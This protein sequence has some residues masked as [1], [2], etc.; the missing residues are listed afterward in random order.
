[1]WRSWSAM[2][3][4]I[5]TGLFGRFTSTVPRHH[6]LAV[7]GSHH[8]PEVMH[9]PDFVPVS[10]QAMRSKFDAIGR[11][12]EL[13]MGKPFF[14][15]DA[16]LDTA[17]RQIGV[18]AGA[19]DLV[20]QA[21]WELADRRTYVKWA[22]RT[23]DVMVIGMP[24]S[25]HYGDGMG[26]NP[27]LM[28]Q[29]IS[30]QIIRQQ[31]V[32]SDHPVV[33]CSSVCDGYFHDEEFPAYREVYGLFQRDRAATLPDVEKFGEALSRD[34]RYIDAYRYRYGYHPFHLHDDQL[35]THRR[36]EVRGHLHEWGEGAGL[37]RVMGMNTRAT[38][39]EALADARAYRPD[40]A[41]LALPALKTAR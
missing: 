16:V 10:T 23:Y 11:H 30:A 34:Q 40:A 5:H 17:S 4:A 13:R 8:S 41:I 1:M 33:I 15:V 22:K 14:T 37:C 39:E 20:Q 38:F 6:P 26:T 35:R 25:F 7:V 12:M 36:T 21:C 3:W 9:R 18:Y 2:H 19:A 31:R 28:L 27:I 24:R 32:L 29:A